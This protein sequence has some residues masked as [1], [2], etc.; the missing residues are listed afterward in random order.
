M[1]KKLM[2]YYVQAQAIGGIPA[3]VRLLKLTKISTYEAEGTPDTPERIQLFKSA[4]NTIIEEY[5]GKTSKQDAN[6]LLKPSKH[7]EEIYLR[8]KKEIPQW[9]K[10]TQ[11]G[12]KR[13]TEVVATT[14]Q[15]ER[16]S[17]W[18]LDTMRTKIT[19]LALYSRKTLEHTSGIE[20]MAKD[21]PQYFKAL[22]N[23]R[24]IAADD[25]NTDPRTS[26]FS[27][28]YLQPLGIMSMLDVPIWGNSKMIGV[29]CNEHTMT[30]RTW[31]IEEE[32]FAYN[33]A[34]LAA[35]CIEKSN[36]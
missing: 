17:V 22:L 9:E 10:D 31:K 12:L 4:L 15:V 25:A 11:Q 24:T 14:L 36:I 23:E 3:K 6:V 29:L 8:L 18:V 20:L 35:L 30:K 13:L 33:M 7:F 32:D 28:P 1:G 34:G 21:F 26:A 19:C 5:Q 27:K 2:E 16:S